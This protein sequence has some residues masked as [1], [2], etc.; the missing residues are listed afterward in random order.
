MQELKISILTNVDVCVIIKL[1]IVNEKKGEKMMKKLPRLPDS[2]LD[3]MLTLWREG[4]PMRILH[5]YWKNQI[6]CFLTIGPFLLC[7]F[8]WRGCMTKD[9]Y[10]WKKRE[11]KRFTHQ[12]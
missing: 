6:R 2:E 8:C 10:I 5:R 9:F 3:V 1:T 12:M 4:Q 7:K 11:E